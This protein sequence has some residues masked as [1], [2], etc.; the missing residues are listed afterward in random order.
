M[1][2]NLKCGSTLKCGG[3][4]ICCV[5]TTSFFLPRKH[6]HKGYSVSLQPHPQM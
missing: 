2:L 3:G 6:K 5:C 4:K 1:L